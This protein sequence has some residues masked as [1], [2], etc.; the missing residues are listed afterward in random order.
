MLVI[1]SWSERLMLNRKV[2]SD[3]KTHF[4]IQPYGRCSQDGKIQKTA[5]WILVPLRC[6]SDIVSLKTKRSFKAIKISS[7]VQPFSDLT[8]VVE[9][10][11]ACCQGT[12]IHTHKTA[13][14]LVLTRRPQQADVLRKL[15][16]STEGNWTKEKLKHNFYFGLKIWTC[17][18]CI[19]ILVTKVF[20]FKISCS[21]L[22]ILENS[23]NITFDWTL[24]S[25][26]AMVLSFSIDRSL[27]IWRK[28]SVLRKLMQLSFSLLKNFTCIYSSS[29]L[30]DFS[31]VLVTGD[32][33]FH[34]V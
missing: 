22:D 29:C 16:H 34:S 13:L 18:S 30:R 6:Q 24:K 3:T 27:F 10:M 2:C 17:M 25:F 28:F 4:Q 8:L 31:C 26:G 19:F 21:I 14:S 5:C 15:H 1:I 20:R 23:P 11:G 9:R 33:G 12:W 32:G 7:V